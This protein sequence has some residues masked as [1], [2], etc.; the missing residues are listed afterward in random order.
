MEKN[1]Q[2]TLSGLIIDKLFLSFT[3]YL[4]KSRDKMR[5]NKDKLFND[6]LL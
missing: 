1:N 5:V 3:F 4:S 2:K 6:S